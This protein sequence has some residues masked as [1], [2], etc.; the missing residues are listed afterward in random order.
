[1]STRGAIP[2][3]EKYSRQLIENPKQGVRYLGATLPAST[4]YRM[5]NTSSKE[6]RTVYA[7]PESY[8]RTLPSFSL[9]YSIYVDVPRRRARQIPEEYLY[10]QK[11]R[12]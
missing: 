10:Q 11:I 6:S 9:S 7:T 3:Q 1:M 12:K 4:R 2:I 5:F 8:D